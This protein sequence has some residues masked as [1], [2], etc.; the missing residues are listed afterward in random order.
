MLKVVLSK[1]Q[2]YLEK[3]LVLISLGKSFSYFIA[4]VEEY[5]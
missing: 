2:E 1:N 3:F 4:L 5:D